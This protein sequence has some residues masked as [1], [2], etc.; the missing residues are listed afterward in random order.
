[1]GTP[2]AGGRCYGSG[3][4]HVALIA[5]IAVITC[6]ACSATSS[7]TPSVPPTSASSPEGPASSPAP[8]TADRA[9]EPSLAPPQPGNPPA[10]T[11]AA[12]D[13]DRLCAQARE[14][15]FDEEQVLSCKL[16]AGVAAGPGRVDILEV[17]IEEAGYGEMTHAL[18]VLQSPGEEPL[19]EALGEAHD[20][21]GESVSYSLSPLQVDGDRVGVT[22]T[23]TTTTYPNTG[24]PDGP[25]G[26]YDETSSRTLVC[27]LVEGVCD[28]A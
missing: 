18:L 6:L 19:F 17:T 10:S 25:S 22:V 1:M 28:E 12:P 21:P 11:H 9:T 24:D 23:E 26:E 14:W 7:G 27:D 2:F 20:V 13:A 8:P 4:R 15:E 16:G 5:V 3:M